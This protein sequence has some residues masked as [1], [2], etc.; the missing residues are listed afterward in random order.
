VAR[1]HRE[2]VRANPALNLLYRIA[3]GAVGGAVLAVGLLLIP[4]P[5]PGWLVVFLGLAILASEFRWARRIN[6]FARRQYHRWASW[7]A[8]QHPS[9]KVAV[10]CLVCAV[11]LLT[12][13][14]AGVF[15]VANNWLGLEWDWL[16]SPL[17]GR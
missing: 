15:G 11:V 14:V 4:Y 1:R 2:R 6:G 3:L 16:N 7:L 17:G 13:W 8:R 12:C 5:G 10:T 9:V